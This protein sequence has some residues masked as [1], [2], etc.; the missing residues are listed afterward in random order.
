MKNEKSEDRLTQVNGISRRS[1]IKLS[2]GIASW[3]TLSGSSF[4]LLREIEKTSGK[5]LQ[6]NGVKIIPTSCAY[7]CGGRCVLKAHV[8]DGVIIRFDT[9]DEPDSLKFPQIRAC[10][11]GRSHRKK[12]YSPYRIKY[13]MKRA[14]ERGEGKFKRITWDEAYDIMAERMTSIKNKYG[15]A[16]IFDGGYA[17]QYGSAWGELYTPNPLL[18]WALSKRFLNLFGSRVGYWDTYSLEGSFFAT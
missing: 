2:S 4:G 1:F 3:M 15:S 10:W 5:A 16:A 12:I 14:G 18:Y 17:G 8:K 11:R 13:P 9:D 7:D 6:K